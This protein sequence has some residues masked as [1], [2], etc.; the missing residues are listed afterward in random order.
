M[1]A[2][3]VHIVMNYY[4]KGEAPWVDP[5][6]LLEIVDNASKTEPLLIGKIAPEIAIPRLDVE[7]TLI[8][9]EKEE[10]EK[11]KFVLGEKV[12]LHGLGSPYKVLFIWAPDCGHCKKSMPKMIDFY[13]K[14]KDK[15]VELFA[16]CHQNYK[17]TPACAEFIKDRPEMLKWI[18]VTDP[19][20]RSRYHTLYLSLIHI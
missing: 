4:A 13:E 3:Y 8:A 15:G 12:S 9:M 1:D 16:L 17:S 14:Y 6:K 2:V 11:D 7:A 20:F 19:Y 5:E 18:N 10:D